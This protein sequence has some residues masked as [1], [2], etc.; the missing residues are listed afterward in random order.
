MTDDIIAAA[1]FLA[2]QM[3]YTKH[4]PWV[5]EAFRDF[6]DCASRVRFIVDGPSAKKYLGPC[7]AEV[8]ARAMGGYCPHGRAAGHFESGPLMHNFDGTLCDGQDTCEGDVYG[9][10]G[11]AKGTCRT[12]GAQVDQGE[13]RAWLDEQVLAHLADTPLRAKDIAHA[14]RLSANTIR[15][16]S[17]TVY[18]ANG[19]VTRLAK[20]SSYW[21]DGERFV[22]WVE[23]R[24]GEDVKA[25]GPRLHYVG[26]VQELARKAADR[27]VEA[28]A[29][30]ERRDT[31]E[32]AA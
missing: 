30:R 19:K 5:D 7:G 28:E 18:D 1:R 24:E 3:E 31:Q 4:Q 6:A 22:P 2:S 29:R 23:P 21:W 27:R 12:C 32:V 13:R 16:W 11:G 20:L 10:A 8:P 25:R 17:H 15:T 26:D 14:L 9:P